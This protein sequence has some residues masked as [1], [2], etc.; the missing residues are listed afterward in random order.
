[1]AFRK[2]LKFPDQKLFKKSKPVVDIDDDIITLIDD[3]RDTLNVAGGVGLAAPQIGALHRVIYV[4]C[5]AFSGAMINPVIKETHDFGAAQEQ[6]L[7][8]PGVSEIIPRYSKIIVEY[9]D[10]ASQQQTS[11]FTNLAAQIIQHEIDHLDG[12][13][14]VHHLSRLKQN[15]IR[16]RVDKVKGK[17]KKMLKPS[18][19]SSHGTRVKTTG[20]LSKKEVKLR[21][22]RRKQNL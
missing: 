13:L 5:D 6:C 10:L 12:R 18:N 4:A 22:K 14:M 9:K 16:R 19:D 15:M 21:R 7:S 1:M 20:H 17:V 11:T 2:I 3:L 8:F